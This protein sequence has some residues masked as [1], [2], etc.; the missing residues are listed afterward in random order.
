MFS[1]LKMLQDYSRRRKLQHPERYDRRNPSSLED[2]EGVDS[3]LQLAEGMDD[4]ELIARLKVH[5]FIKRAYRF[6][7][8]NEPPKSPRVCAT[9]IELENRGIKVY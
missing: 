2:C 4:E 3:E 7:R 9:E 6:L 8:L 5:E 1:E